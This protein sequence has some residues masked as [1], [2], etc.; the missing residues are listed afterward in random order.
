MRA[1]ATMLWSVAFVQNQ[2]KTTREITEQ[3]LDRSLELNTC[4]SMS[5][6]CGMEAAPAHYHTHSFH[7]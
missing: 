3:F 7:I 4:R 2:V 6:D 5:H 1:T